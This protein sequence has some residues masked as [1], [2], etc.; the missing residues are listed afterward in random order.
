VA[1]MLILSVFLMFSK[2]VAQHCLSTNKMQTFMQQLVR[3]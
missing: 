2:T 3:L 1:G